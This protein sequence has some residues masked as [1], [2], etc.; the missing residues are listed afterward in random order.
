L[1]FIQSPCSSFYNHYLEQVIEI[2]KKVREKWGNIN[3][4]D[5]STSDSPNWGF[6][7][8]K[9]LGRV[10]LGIA[11][12]ELRDLPIRGIEDA[13]DVL[14]KQKEWDRGQVF[15][16]GTPNHVIGLRVSVW[17]YFQIK[18]CELKTYTYISH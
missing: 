10:A 4:T 7:N 18:M 14:G 5:S 2:A 1:L 8:M 12:E 11:K 16:T 9:K 17:G 13:V 3:E 6:I 15:N